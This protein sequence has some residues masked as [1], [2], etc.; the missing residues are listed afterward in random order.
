MLI[1][2]NLKWVLKSLIKQDIL[3]GWIVGQDFRNQV[4]AI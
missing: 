4:I 1:F 3:I 2:W